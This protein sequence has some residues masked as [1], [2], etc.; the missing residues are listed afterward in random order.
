M[1]PAVCPPRQDADMKC[2][3]LVKE[4]YC[5]AEFMQITMA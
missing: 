5:L 3:A 1:L 2:H 4:V